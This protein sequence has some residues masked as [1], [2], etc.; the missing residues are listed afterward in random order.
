MVR[1]A[2]ELLQEH[3]LGE[4]DIHVRLLSS[5]ER[6][7][8][9]NLE[10]GADSSVMEFRPERNY[11]AIGFVPHSLPNSEALTIKQVESLSRK[12]GLDPSAFELIGLWTSQGDIGDPEG[13]AKANVVDT[14]L[15]TLGHYDEP[16]V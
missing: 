13:F 6:N 1:W 11:M 9:E 2:N 16:G 5:D 12:M 7:E 15:E 3:G 14:L 4:F 10:P 8:I